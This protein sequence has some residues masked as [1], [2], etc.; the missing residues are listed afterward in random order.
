[1]RT[2]GLPEILVILGLIVLLTGGVGISRLFGWAGQRVRTAANRAKWIYESL[3]GTEESE[4]RA[5]EDAGADMAKA[6]LASMPPDP[7]EEAQALVRRIGRRLAETAKAK[8]RRFVFRVVQA[9]EANAFALPGGYVFVTRRLLELCG[10]EDEVAYLLAHEMGHV[11]ER[12]PAEQKLVRTLMHAL[13]AGR[14]ASELLGKAYSREQEHEA[15]QKA[16]ELAGEAGFDREAGLRVLRKLG[17]AAPE[18][19]EITR[20]FS[21]HPSTE[22]RLEHLEAALVEGGVKKS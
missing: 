19:G 22:E 15:D 5:E 4:I 16:M 11:L 20:Y 17:K 12:H 8:K 7:D 3:G 10:G 13:R 21:T 1:M 6:F 2:L 14:F 9:P 18:T